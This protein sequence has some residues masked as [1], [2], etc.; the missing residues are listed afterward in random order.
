MRKAILVIVSLL[1]SVYFIV[2]S[3]E[4]KQNNNITNTTFS[5]IEEECGNR[6][7]VMYNIVYDKEKDSE[8]ANSI[9]DTVYK[10][11]VREFLGE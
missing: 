5:H 7:N 8:K 3:N 6:K 10:N 4:S 1:L 11:C 2:Y 9:S